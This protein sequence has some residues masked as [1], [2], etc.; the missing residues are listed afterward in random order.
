LHF[1][2]PEGAGTVDPY[3]SACWAVADLRAYLVALPPTFRER[4][5]FPYLR[6]LRAY[7]YSPALALHLME[8][9]GGQLTPEAALKA[10]VVDF[11]EI[12]I[13]LGRERQREAYRTSLGF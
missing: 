13:R 10:T 5:Q 4:Q 7:S 3:L 12:T 2:P 6:I 11:E 8:A 1:L 9:A